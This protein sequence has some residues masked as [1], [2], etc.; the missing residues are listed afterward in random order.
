M[1]SIPSSISSLGSC[2]FSQD[3]MD[4]IL[5][6][7]SALAYLCQINADYREIESFLTAFPEAL[8]FDSEQNEL[9]D[10]VVLQM[11]ECQC[12]GISCNLNR[13]CILRAI[14]R[15]F[16]FYRNVRLHFRNDDKDN[17]L[18]AYSSHLRDIEHERR[19]L[20]N[21][22]VDLEA[23]VAHAVKG[24]ADL[25]KQIEEVSKKG[26]NSGQ[27]NVLLKLKCRKMHP[28]E[29]EERTELEKKLTA[30]TVSISA[31]EKEQSLLQ[32][33]IATASRLELA[34]LKQCFSDC[35]RH[36]C[37]APRIDA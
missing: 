1:L 32:T 18:N 6:R 31:L 22:Q 15:G 21:H 12:F 33:E 34:L 10:L 9:E 36:M 14:R 35:K 17:I 27:M 30:T 13:R 28:H 3:S 37:N 20:E 23:N 5:V 7:K 29:F 25:R 4:D 24:I 2:S 8:L 11:R 16:E 26:T 19:I